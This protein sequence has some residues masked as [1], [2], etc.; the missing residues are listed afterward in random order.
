M[1]PKRLEQIQ[2]LADEIGNFK[3]CYAVCKLWGSLPDGDVDAETILAWLIENPHMNELA[4][5][6]KKL[7]T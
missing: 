1:T 7:D 5:S 3:E 4:L 6:I 2:K